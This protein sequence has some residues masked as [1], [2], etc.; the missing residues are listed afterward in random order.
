MFTK[1]FGHDSG[2]LDADMKT[3]IN[4]GLPKTPVILLT[5]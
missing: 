2:Q 4:S 5:C 1:C 3:T